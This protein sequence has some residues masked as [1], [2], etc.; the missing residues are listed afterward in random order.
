MIDW[1]KREN[2]P[3]RVAINRK[4]CGSTHVPLGSRRAS[5][6]SSPHWEGLPASKRGLRI[7][8]RGED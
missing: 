5:G 6:L 3:V 2:L 4:K 7:G 8:E 1:G